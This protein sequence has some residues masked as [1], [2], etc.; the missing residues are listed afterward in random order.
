MAK[1][2]D[3]PLGEG[4]PTKISNNTLMM[5]GIA[6]LLVIYAGMAVGMAFD[7]SVAENDGKFVIYKAILNISNAVDYALNPVNTIKSAFADTQSWAFKLGIASGVILLIYFGYKD[8]N[9]KRYHRKGSEHGS[10]YWGKDKE[11]TIIQD[12][13]DLY[14]NIIYADDIFMVLDRKKRDENAGK[15]KK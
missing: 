8:T 15:K 2:N 4:M 5:M 10:A 13:N 12:P 1:A 7:E 14:N 3:N 11:K 6:L 9:K